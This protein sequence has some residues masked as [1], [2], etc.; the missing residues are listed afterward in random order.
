M[1]I[2]YRFYPKSFTFLSQFATLRGV[3]YF[4]ASHECPM[5]DGASTSLFVNLAFGH[6]NNFA[7]LQDFI[8][9]MDG[10]SEKFL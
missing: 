1:D 10:F 8:S 4:L 3:Y 6:K 9:V 5:N 2:P 7:R